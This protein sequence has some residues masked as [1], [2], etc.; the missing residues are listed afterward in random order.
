MRDIDYV[1]LGATL[2]TPATHKDIKRIASG[3]KFPTLRSVVF[4]LEDAIKDDEVQSGVKNIFTFLD[5][6]EQKDIKVFIR[7]HDPQNL[8]QLLEYKHI[9]K[10]DGFALAKFGTQNMQSYFNTLQQ[11][12]HSF[13]IMPVL[14]STDIFD[15][16]KLI[17]IRN[18]LLQ[19][20]KD[21]ILTLRVGAEDM[22]Q[23]IGIKKCC[24]DS[25]HDFHISKTVFGELLGIFK[26]YGFNIA[27]PV[28]NCLE[29][30]E[31]FTKEV[32]RDLKEGFFGKTIIHPDQGIIANE[33]YKVNQSDYNEAS[34]ILDSSKDAIFRFE[35]KMCEPKA[36]KRWATYIL[37]RA[38]YY[39]IQNGKNF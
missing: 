14:E 30:S 32:Q 26:P 31:F 13:H 29:N 9:S 4:C 19:Q 8:Q 36:H 39:G 7:P 28:Y 12:Q 33:C 21:T 3:D 5:H 1:E 18:F 22:F 17:Q 25:I 34:M 10:I 27:A 15:K 20:K 23:M 24:E 38:Y 11:T 35:K 2:Y 6:Y 37:K 16:E